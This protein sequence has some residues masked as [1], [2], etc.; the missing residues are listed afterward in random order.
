MSSLTDPDVGGNSQAH[1]WKG[2]SAK[3][4]NKGIGGNQ[5]DEE[6]VQAEGTLPAK[7]KHEKT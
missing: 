1:P 3:M 4:R 2:C 7:T 6:I 5:G